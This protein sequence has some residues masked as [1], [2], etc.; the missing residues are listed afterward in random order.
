MSSNVILDVQGLNVEF[1]TG[2][3]RVLAVDN[4]TL[5]LERGEI[6]GIAG[7]SGSGKSTLVYAIARMLAPAGRVSAGTVKIHPAE[8]PSIDFL[9]L[10]GVKL[11]EVRWTRMAVVPQAAMNAL[12]PVLTIGTQL[13][14]VLKTHGAGKTKKDRR[15]RA[16]ELLSIVGIPAARLGA[17]PHQMSGGMRQRVMI[18]MALALDPDILILDE[19]TTALDV[20]TQRQIV[21]EIVSL[22]QRMGLSIIFVTHDL[23]LLFE[24]ADRVAVMYAGR[25]V[26]LGSADRV[27]DNPLHPYSQALSASFPTL[28][29]S[30]AMTSRIPGSPP[31]LR[32][33]PTGCRFHPRCR[34]ATEACAQIVPELRN[35]TALNDPGHLVA[36]HLHDP[37]ID[38][39]HPVGAPT[40]GSDS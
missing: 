28:E 26:E 25:L 12:N 32:D 34:F 7:E 36:C 2:E 27:R 14:D 23:G 21:D 30:P 8:G 31:S 10:E 9:D 13:T 15:E 5:Q 24:L 4:A 33:L 20:V 17:Y 39:P 3:S 11:R 22:R 18:A 38:M 37:A 19:P 1:G 40:V 6:L 29:R 16:A 35:P